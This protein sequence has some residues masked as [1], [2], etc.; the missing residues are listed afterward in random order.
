VRLYAISALTRALGERQ[1][2]AA[3][4]EEATKSS[5]REGAMYMLARLCVF[6]YIF[7]LNAH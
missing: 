2:V 5:A 4:R 3:V 6:S 7:F 1:V